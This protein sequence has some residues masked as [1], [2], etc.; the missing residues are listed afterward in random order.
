MDNFL[1]ILASIALLW[2]IIIFWAWRSNVRDKKAER[3]SF[4]NPSSLSFRDCGCIFKT[5][6]ISEDKIK[7]SYMQLDTHF[8]GNNEI[9]E[10]LPI[11]S[12][13]LWY[14]KYNVPPDFQNVNSIFILQN[15]KGK[16]KFIPYKGIIYK[17]MH[18]PFGGGEKTVTRLVEA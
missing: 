16:F 4:L 13:D 14:Y 15:D 2:A 8:K 7:L 3:E 10:L 6:N 9:E 18:I 1:I 17:E 5:M 11:Y 12:V